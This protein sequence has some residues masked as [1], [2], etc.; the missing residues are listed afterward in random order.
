MRGSLSATGIWV[1]GRS[2]A[3][4]VNLV[5]GQRDEK[6]AHQRTHN[7]AADDGQRHRELQV[8]TH[9]AV[10]QERRYGQ[11]RRERGH[12]DGSGAAARPP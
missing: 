1:A 9:V 2:S 11:D 10:G 12:D 7:H 5:I 6:Y 4:S 8:G 3:G